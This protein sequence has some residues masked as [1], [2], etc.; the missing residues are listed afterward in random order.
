MS[1]DI[2]IYSSDTQASK[3]TL[4]KLRKKLDN[5]GFTLVEE[6]D[7]DTE[8]IVIIGGDGTFLRA[9]HALDFPSTPLIGINTGHLGFFQE[10]M[11]DRLDDFI[12]NYTQGRYSLQPMQTVRAV[13]DHAGVSEEITGLN[14]I[15]IASADNFSHSVHFNISIGGSFIERFS[16]DGLLISTPAGSTAYNYSLGG[17]IVD[18]RLKLLQATPIAP[19]NTTAYR[20]FTS[21]IL[22]P[23]DLTMS[24]V[25]DDLP[26]NRDITVAYDGISRHYDDIERV[27]VML[28]DTTIQLM[29]FE[30]YDFWT[31]VKSKFL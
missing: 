16:G 10:I 2:Y 13:I 24:I 20:S 5:L 19:M 23:P 4:R 22:L 9:I 27:E 6:P 15:I 21:S 31:K 17:S 18:P 29:R 28:S 7:K 26:L 1:R 8:L 11:P 25:P 12:Y 3:Q 14:E 30:S